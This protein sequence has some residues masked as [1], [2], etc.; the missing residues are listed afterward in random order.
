[1]GKELRDKQG[2]SYS[3]KSNL[4]IRDHGGYWN[5][6]TELDQANLSKMIHGIFA[7]IEKVQKEGV[8]DEELEKAQARRIAM[9][10]MNT[11]TPDEIG[12]VIFDLIQEK[13]PLD[14]FDHSKERILAVT[15]AD[16][17]RVANKYL[18]TQNYIIA[19][20]GN[21]APDALNEFK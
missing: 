14:Y 13:K 15:K 6:R 7:E 4:W 1:M 17:Q 3:I 11:R 2:L 16:I 12:A 20:S 18:D 19:V 10:T 5:I 8:T 9:L 21:M